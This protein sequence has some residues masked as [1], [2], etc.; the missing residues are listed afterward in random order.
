MI[1]RFL[2]I[3][4]LTKFYVTDMRFYMDL[5]L[6]KLPRD[7]GALFFSCKFEIHCKIEM[8]E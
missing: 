5:M 1:G 4:M 3:L 2:P 7:I 8:E 6:L